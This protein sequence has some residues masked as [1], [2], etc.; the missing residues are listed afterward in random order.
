MYYSRSLLL[1]STVVQTARLA[2]WDPDGLMVLAKKR[3][4]SQWHGDE[5]LL[6]NGSRDDATGS[7]YKAG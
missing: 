6:V 2:G 3:A 4:F 7:M 1:G 5:V